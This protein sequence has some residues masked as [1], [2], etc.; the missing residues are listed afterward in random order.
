M[1]HYCMVEE[2]R[3]VN[4]YCMVE[5]DKCESLLHGGGRQKCE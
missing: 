3:N 2:D 1:N 4:H 5:E